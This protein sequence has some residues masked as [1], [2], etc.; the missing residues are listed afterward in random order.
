MSPQFTK[1]QL[2]AIAVIG[3]R[4]YE[5]GRNGDARAI[6]EG[7]IRLDDTLYYGYAGLGAIDLREGNLQGA[8]EHLRKAAERN[9]NDAS[10]HT[11]LGETL[12]RLTSF[13]D[14][15]QEFRKAMELDPQGHDPGANRARAILN[16]IEAALLSLRAGAAES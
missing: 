15:A 5:D 16:G 9:P 11:N 1:E 7:L 13:A 14:S 6:F 12:L 3:L 10:V 4:A 8:L 2:D